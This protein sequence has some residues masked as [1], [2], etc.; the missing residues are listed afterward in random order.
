[1][2]QVF[3]GSFACNDIVLWTCHEISKLCLPGTLVQLLKLAVWSHPFRLFLGEA[4][5]K[6]QS[7]GL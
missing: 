3:V 5:S 2:V 7:M 6:K 4:L 1:M